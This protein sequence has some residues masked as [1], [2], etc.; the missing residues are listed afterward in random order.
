MTPKEAYQI[1]GL[2]ENTSPRRIKDRYRYL[3]KC[4]HPDRLINQ[5]ERVRAAERFKQ[6][7]KAY[8]TLLPIARQTGLSPQDRHLN[9]LYEQGQKLCEQKKWSQALAI[10]TEI[11]TL[12]LSYKDT[13][14]LLREARRKHKKLLALYAEAEHYLQQRNWAEAKERFERV[15]QHDPT[16][17]DTSQKLKRARRELLQQGFLER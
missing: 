17:R 4:Y 12:N 5:A 11:L 10:F 3:A 1:L 14:T 6:I 13:L 16:Y 9:A 2:P 8:K 15:A 7:S